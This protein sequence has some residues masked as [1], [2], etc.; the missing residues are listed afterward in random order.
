MSFTNFKVS[1]TKK[2]GMKIY[3]FLV[4]TLQHYKYYSFISIFASFE[5]VPRGVS[6]Y[7]FP[8]FLEILF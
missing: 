2:S 5:R 3:T 4:S 7:V 6:V 1:D 8:N